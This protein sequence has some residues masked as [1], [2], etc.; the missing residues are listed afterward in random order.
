[1]ASGMSKLQEVQTLKP[2]LDGMSQTVKQYSGGRPV[3]PLD[4]STMTAN[5]ETMAKAA[6]AEVGANERLSAQAL[7]WQPSTLENGMSRTQV[8]ENLKAT[9]ETASQAKRIADRIAAEKA[10]LNKVAQNKVQNQMQTAMKLLMNKR[11][12]RA[13]FAAKSSLAEDDQKAVDKLQ[14]VLQ[15]A[16]LEDAKYAAEAKKLR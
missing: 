16:R 5:A 8:T 2:T 3:A 7:L 4:V 14:I 11:A 12:A 1:M 15:A 6:A 9:A 13:T 10:V